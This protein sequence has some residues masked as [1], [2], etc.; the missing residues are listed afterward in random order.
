MANLIKE[1]E[2]G[3]RKNILFASET[4]VTL[5]V[6]VT[7]TGLQADSN[8]KKIIKAGTAI[9]GTTNVLENRNTA[10]V[11][12]NNSGSAANSQGVLLHDVDVTD[13]PANGVIVIAGYIYLDKLEESA[14]PVDGVKTALK[15]VVRFVKGV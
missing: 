4:A 3:I 8:G 5:P 11:V 12:T 1:T 14:V 10:L 15:G 7:N 9:G 6:Q 2:Y 13:G